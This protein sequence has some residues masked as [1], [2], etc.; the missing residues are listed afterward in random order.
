VLRKRKEEKCEIPLQGGEEKTT[1][2]RAATIIGVDL[3]FTN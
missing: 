3:I 1:F 2:L